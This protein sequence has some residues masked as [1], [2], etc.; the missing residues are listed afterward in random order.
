MKK[1][2]F[3]VLAY[4]FS[5]GLG[6]LAAEIGLRLVG[7]KL[8]G[9]YYVIDPELG[10]ALRPGAR[11]VYTTEGE[12]EVRI[13]AQGMRDDRVFERSR[14]PGVKRIAVLGDSF[15]EAMQVDVSK[16]FAA[17]LE[18]R[19]GA[20]VM[21]FGVQGY[22]TAQQLLQW[23]RVV[24]G[25]SPD[26]TVLLFYTGN[27]IY[28]NHR[29]LNPT[30]ADAAPYFVMRNGKMELQPA[31]AA[32]SAW[33]ELWAGAAEWIYLVR[34]VAEN[35][36]KYTRRAVKRNLP[37]DYMDRLIYRE[38]ESRE[39][40]EAWEVTERLLEK[41]AAEIPNLY[42]V[43]VSSGIQAHPEATAREEFL[44]HFEGQDLCYVE[45]R[46]ERFCKARGLRVGVLADWLRPLAEQRKIYFYGFAGN[47]GGGHW[48]EAG[49]REVADYLATWLSGGSP[50][51]QTAHSP[52]PL[53]E[54][55][56]R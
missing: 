4:G 36:Y 52:V 25:Y 6:L 51:G 48:N 2:L 16:T 30:N 18:K 29:A 14:K 46:L 44:R 55:P 1:R 23:R 45:R 3:T 27:D 19:T 12:A 54:S 32:P 50:P 47:L 21:N 43:I 9:S 7:A 28:N 10:W 56:S 5:I 26:A 40:R 39:M 22:G 17:L 41:M 49:H 37:E 15:A 53:Q 35:Y 11:G 13:N 34:F 33:R 31:L 42:V 24:R 38:P 8:S 20:E